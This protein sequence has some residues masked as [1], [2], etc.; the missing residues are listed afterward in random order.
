MLRAL[1]ST[2]VL[3]RGFFVLLKHAPF[4]PTLSR[5]TDWLGLDAQEVA[6]E[7]VRIRMSTD[8]HFWARARINGVE[9]RMLIDSGATVTALS[10]RTAA[11]AGVQPDLS[12]LPMVLRTA[13]GVVSA[14]TATIDTLA[15]GGLEAR[16][17]KAVI[18]PAQARSTSWA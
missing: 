12:P 6:G 2:G 5:M 1:F 14:R 4:D 18:S 16:K 13:N 7:E 9:R 8:G 10:D 15:L 17:L 11:Q 3:A